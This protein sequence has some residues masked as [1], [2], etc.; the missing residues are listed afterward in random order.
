MFRINRVA[1]SPRPCIDEQRPLIDLD[2]HSC[3]VSEPSKYDD[4]LRDLIGASCIG[5]D[6]IEKDDDVG[7]A[8]TPEDIVLL[9]ESSSVCNNGLVK[10]R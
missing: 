8:E 1:S 9:Q 10:R 2:S 3:E 4:Q 6:N 5:A 7:C